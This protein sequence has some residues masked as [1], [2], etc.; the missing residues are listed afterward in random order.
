MGRPDMLEA[1]T[2]CFP[3]RD[4]HNWHKQRFA[5]DG[6]RD[7]VSRR[8]QGTRHRRRVSTTSRIRCGSER[9]KDVPSRVHQHDRNPADRHG[10]QNG[11]ISLDLDGVR[12]PVHRLRGKPVG[13]DHR[14]VLEREQA[15]I[16]RASFI[17]TPKIRKGIR[18]YF[19]PRCAS[20]RFTR[21]P[22]F[23]ATIFFRKR[24]FAPRSQA[25]N[26]GTR[27]LLLTCSDTGRTSRVP[28]WKIKRVANQL[29]GRFLP[30]V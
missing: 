16:A 4:F 10:G 15:E 17:G 20:V 21:A 13:H 12:S 19:R 18:A 8:D 25:P 3:Q 14:G 7:A 26:L 24:P 11:G 9:T 2:G 6:T 1:E 23:S 30:R 5:R 28:H 22:S 27:E 29:G